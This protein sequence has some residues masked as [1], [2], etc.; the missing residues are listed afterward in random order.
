MKEVMSD[1]CVYQNEK[2]LE[3]MKEVDI[4]GDGEVKEESLFLLDGLQ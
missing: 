3:M 4:D 1:E 2:L